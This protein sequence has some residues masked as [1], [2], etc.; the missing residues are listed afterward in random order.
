MPP[1]PL[2]T[3]FLFLACVLVFSDTH[4]PPHVMVVPSLD[5]QL[6]KGKDGNPSPLLSVFPLFFPFCSYPVYYEWYLDQEGPLK[7]SLI[8]FVQTQLISLKAGGQEESVSLPFFFP[9]LL[10]PITSPPPGKE[11][12]SSRDFISK[13][14]S[15]IEVSPC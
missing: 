11:M 13:H 7:R 6:I 2:L 14:L 1:L 12:L 8:S 4:L 10:T 15:V 3:A 9:F 5:D